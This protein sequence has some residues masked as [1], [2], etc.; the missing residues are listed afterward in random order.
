MN[1]T[2]EQLA[3]V[4]AGISRAQTAIIDAV[5]SNTGGWRNTHFNPKITTAANLRLKDARLVDIPSRILMRNQTRVPMTTEQ[6]IKDLQTAIGGAAPAAPAAAA[7]APAAV[8][9]TVPGDD[10]LN[11][12]KN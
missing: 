3:E 1:I 11:F 9:S 10:E 12:F 4:L 2:I 5:E 8:A 6:I 7:A